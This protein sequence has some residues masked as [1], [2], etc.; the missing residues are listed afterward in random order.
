ML[1][2]LII[3]LAVCCLAMLIPASALAHPEGANFT[4]IDGVTHPLT[5]IEHFLT[6]LCVGLLSAQM[7][8]RAI[9]MVPLTFVSVMAGASVWGAIDYKISGDTVWLPIRIGIVL[10][11]IVLGFAIYR[12]KKFPI[13]IAMI[14]TA[15]FAV[16]H[17][18]LHGAGATL[19]LSLM[20]YT[21]G[22][23]LT[24]A[25]IH[26]FGAIIGIE[27]SRTPKRAL[28]LRRIGLIICI[29]GIVILILAHKIIMQYL[30]NLIL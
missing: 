4:F 29:L 2:Y 11:L 3:R 6:M 15:L 18:Y 26:I 19:A 7:G 21:A 20:G 27:L 10:S 23:M 14:F 16:C 25:G 1:N 30:A 22:F 9:W 17:G 5:G 12:E 13:S 28:W 8:G 24:T